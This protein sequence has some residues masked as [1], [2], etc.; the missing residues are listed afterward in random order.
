MR[1]LAF[2]IAF[3]AFQVY[4]FQRETPTEPHLAAIAG[5]IAGHVDV[6]CPSI[7]KRLIEV[8]SAQGTAHYDPDDRPR[9]LSARS[10]C[11]LAS[12]S[13]RSRRLSRAS[14]PR[15]T[16]SSTFTRPFLK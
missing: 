6:Y 11:R 14:F 4:W 10:I 5:S 3:V 12:R 2:L 1:L 8:S 13:A 9:S 7:W 16:A 15:A